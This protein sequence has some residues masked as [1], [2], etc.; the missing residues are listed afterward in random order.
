MH[1]F[2]VLGDP[3]RR[4]IMELLSAGEQ[5]S[6]D[7][8]I[9]IAKEFGIS[10]PAVSHQLKVLRQNG[11]TTVRPDAQRRIYAVN[12]EPFAEIEDWLEPFRQFWDKK[13][14]ALATEVARGKKTR[15]SK[16]R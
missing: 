9:V 6:G 16:D 2:D 3:V 14:V 15:K 5:S 12:S 4:R 7:I 11:F 13:L 8:V 1:A 10:Q